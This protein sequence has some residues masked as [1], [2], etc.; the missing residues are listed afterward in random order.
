MRS[1]VIL[2]QDMVIAKACSG[3]IVRSE[4]QPEV[5]VLERTFVD[6]GILPQVMTPNAQ[7]IYGRKGT[8]KSHLLRVLG[9]TVGREIGGLAVYLDLRTLG[10][11]DLITDQSRS[12]S[13]RCISLYRDLLSAVQ[14]QLLDVATEP[15]R[16]TSGPGFEEISRLADV[17]RRFAGRVTEREVTSELE[18]SESQGS[19]AGLSLAPR[20][21]GVNLSSTDKS[22]TSAK[23]SNRYTE[24]VEDIL[25][26]A[27][28]AEALGRAISAMEIRRL[29]ILLDEWSAIPP[30]AQPYIADF[31]KRS[32]LP[33]AQ[34]TVK[35]A[36]LQN[37]SRF[38]LVTPQSQRIGFELG[39]DIQAS[40]D[41][42][43][44]YVYDRGPT[45]VVTSFSELLY[46]HL[47]AESPEDY[48]RDK[49]R[50]M[51]REDLATALFVNPHALRELVRA[52]EGIVR[53]F[54]GIFTAC[55]FYALRHGANAIDLISVRESAQSWFETDKAPNLDQAQARVLRNIIAQ[56][57][58][59]ERGR[60]FLIEQEV[61]SHEKIQSLYELR[62]LHLIRRGIS[63]P[64]APGVRYDLFTL[65]YGTYADLL[66]RNEPSRG[67]E[68]APSDSIYPL[69]ASS[70]SGLRYVTLDSAIL[71]TGDEHG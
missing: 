35:I 43:D 68:S 21:L 51:D 10:S 29:W 17:L 38:S 53:D 5:G 19:R 9:A 47:C 52:G 16:S 1:E 58:G 34:V 31:I 27:E 46:R 26:F 37:R 50:I 61:A 23:V 24:A 49:H 36:A 25:V 64:V 45:K 44:Y 70:D 22:A 66:G 11:A 71:S 4:Q 6:T 39:S 15:R 63:N 67:I 69:M 8:G 18:S 13:V 7:I 55:F 40:L 2:I 32:L 48:L 56:V 54:L 3:I 65:D 20:A 12:L 33:V 62:V 30:D 57:V 28:V 60:Y 59:E 14:Y 42:D 41:L